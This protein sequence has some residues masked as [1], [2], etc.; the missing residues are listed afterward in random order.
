M[1]DIQLHHGDCLE[2]MQ[3]I[4][5]KSLENRAKIDIEQEEWNKIKERIYDYF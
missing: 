3:G 2:V 5:D 1:S 4:S